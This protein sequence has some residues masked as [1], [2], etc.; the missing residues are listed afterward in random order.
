MLAEPGEREQWEGISER[1][2]SF[3]YTR[4]V[5]PRDLRNTV[6]IANNTVLY[7][8]NLAERVD[9]R[10][11]VLIT[12]RIITP[13]TIANRR[14]WEETFEEDVSVYGIDCSDGS[15]LDTYLQVH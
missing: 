2:Q 8:K 11:S 6:P 1:S 10:W 4:W 9:L 13:I 5:S 12:D 14:V 7:T 3:I 15:K